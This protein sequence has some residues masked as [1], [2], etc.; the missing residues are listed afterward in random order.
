MLK[1][2][3]WVKDFLS[4][5]RTALSAR[6]VWFREEV[7]SH[8]ELKGALDASPSEA[9]LFVWLDL[10]KNLKEATWGGEEELWRRVLEEAKV[11]LT[12]GEGCGMDQPGFFR[13][14]ICNLDID[15]Y[16]LI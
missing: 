8:D 6:H 13:V 7:E 10:R 1:D 14:C 15:I 16:P 2:K 12:R 11:N 9:A 5:N 3:V 4:Q